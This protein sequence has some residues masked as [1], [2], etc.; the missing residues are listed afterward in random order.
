MSPNPSF[1]CQNVTVS[2]VHYTR[3]P[4]AE[5]FRKGFNAAYKMAAAMAALVGVMLLIVVLYYTWS[6]WSTLLSSYAVW[7]HSLGVV[8]AGTVAGLAG[9]VL[10]E[11]SIV[12]FQHRGRWTLES[13]ENM[14]FKFGFFGITGAM[15]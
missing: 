1:S 9:G 5:A 8:G 12:Y 2:G 6:P 13:L 14:L 3:A 10:S 4:W 15:V 7:Q 11:L